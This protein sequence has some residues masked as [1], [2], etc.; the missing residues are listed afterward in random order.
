MCMEHADRTAE[1]RW[2]AGVMVEIAEAVAEIWGP[3][4]DEAVA[5]VRWGN[6]ADAPRLDVTMDTRAPAQWYQVDHPRTSMF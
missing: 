3:A 5:G 4:E 2:N 6:T 1:Q